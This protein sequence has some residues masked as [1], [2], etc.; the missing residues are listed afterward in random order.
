M[1]ILFLL[2]C[3]ALFACGLL[4]AQTS[5]AP[6]KTTTKSSARRRSGAHKASATAHKTPVTAHK[7]PVTARKTTTSRTRSRYASNRSHHVTSKN[8]ASSKKSRPA[9]IRR[10][11]QLQPTPERYKEIQEALASKGYFKGTADGAWGAD[12]VDALK[13]FQRDQNLTDDGKIGSLSLIALG[14]GPK[15]A[16]PAAEGPQENKR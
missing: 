14:L 5:A 9:P 4:A 7:G 15:R 8:R 13:R 3:L 12:S 1:R 10:S 6:K 2:N 16:A 11:A